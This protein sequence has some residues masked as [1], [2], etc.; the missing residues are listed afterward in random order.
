MKLE[1]AL[2][3]VSKGADITKEQAHSCIKIMF[4]MFDEM[5]EDE[6]SELVHDHNKIVEQ[7]VE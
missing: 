7:E 1:E 6:L 5:A 2:Q 3:I 4:K